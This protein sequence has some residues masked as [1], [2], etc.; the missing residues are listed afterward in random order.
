MSLAKDVLVIEDVTTEDGVRKIST[1]PSGVC[2]HQI[3]V[4]VKSGVITNVKFWGGCPGNTQGVA[5]LVVGLRVE[6]AISK[7]LGIDCGGKG[8]SCP[9]QLA[10]TLMLFLKK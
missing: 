9:D 2:S 1:S 6:N 5:K 4:E 10:K 3:D 7:L 8:T